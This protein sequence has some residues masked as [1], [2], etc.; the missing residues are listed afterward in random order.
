M[1]NDAV[2][3]RA[4]L[5]QSSAMWGELGK[6][7]SLAIVLNNLGVLERQ[8]LRYDLSQAYFDKS[9]ALMRELSDRAGMALLFSNMGILARFKSDPVRAGALLEES[10]ELCRETGNLYVLEEALG[11][12]AQIA[13]QRGDYSTA[14]E[15]FREVLGLCAGSY[16]EGNLIEALEPIAELAACLQQ[17]E[18]GVRLFASAS[19]MRERSGWSVAPDDRAEYDRRKQLLRVGLDQEVFA[20]E[21]TTGIEM[22][23]A[24]ALALAQDVLKVAA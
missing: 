11:S 15:Q 19:A 17:A 20:Q 13:M 4:L 2:A 12:L 16:S 24:A 9:I 8:E 10:V 1:Q 22:T 14:R 7:H 23:P 6:K 5:T 21:W 18:H 3:A